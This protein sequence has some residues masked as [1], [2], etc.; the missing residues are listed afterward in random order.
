MPDRKSIT[1]LARELR[2]NPTPAEQALWKILRKRRVAGY[3]FLRQKPLIYNQKNFNKYFFI[4]D[5]YCAQKKLVV[6]VDGPYHRYQKIYDQQRD[7]VIS[8][9]DIRVLRINNSELQNP[10]TVR[11]KIYQALQELC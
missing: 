10:E 7:R 9:L 5:F 4:A 3:R 2:N 1:E 6:E 8:G 11:D